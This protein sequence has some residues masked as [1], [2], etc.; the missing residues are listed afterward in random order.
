MTAA[1]RVED[2]L[3]E[4]VDDARANGPVELGA[5]IGHAWRSDPKR[6]AFTLSRYKFVAKMLAGRGRTAEIGAGDGWASAIVAAETGSVDLYDVDSRMGGGLVKAH[7]LVAA[8]LPIEYRS[9]YALDVFE[10]VA[11][12]EADRFLNNAALSLHPR[13]VFVLGAP[14]LESQPYAS[15]ISRAGHINCMSGEGLRAACAARFH[16]VF[17]F[18]MNDEVVHTGFL[19]MS[20]YLLALCCEP[21]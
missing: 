21:R 10:H 14:S 20:H 8:P 12:A 4:C 16:H 3:Q 13:G 6:L 2:P 19:P 9:A 7:D 1:R 17:M 15:E 5:M 11:P 18:G